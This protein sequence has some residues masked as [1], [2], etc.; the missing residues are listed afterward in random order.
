MRTPVGFSLLL[1]ALGFCVPVA[2]RA[3]TDASSPIPAT[4]FGMCPWK[5]T[6]FPPFT[7]GA[8]GHGPFS[9]PQV[10]ATRDAFSFTALEDF[11]LDAAARGMVDPSTNTVPMFVTLG[12]TPKWATTDTTTCTRGPNCN[13]PP[14]D[15]SDWSNY[16][17]QLVQH[18]DGHAF[19]HIAYYELWNEADDRIWWTPPIAQEYTLLNAMA[20]SAYAIVHADPYSQL[21]TP[22]LA[23]NVDKKASWMTTYLQGGGARDAD[24]GCYHG[25]LGSN[26]AA[27]FLWPE[28]ESGEGSV[29]TLAT[30]MRAVFDNC[31]LAGK[32]MYMTE[33]SWGS[34]TVNTLDSLT[35]AAWI[36]R[37]YLLQAGERAGTNLQSVEWFVWDDSS[38]GWGVLEHRNGAP[39][40]AV[41]AF[42]RVYQWLVGARMPNACT[43]DSTTGTWVCAMN[44][45]GGYVARAVWNANGPATWT[46]GSSF[47]RYRTLLGDS[48]AIAPGASI[49]IGTM[50]V[51]VESGVFTND[52]PISPAASARMHAVPA[53]TTAAT[54]LMFGRPPSAAG[55]VLVCD[56]AGRVVRS[57]AVPPGAPSVIW[58]GRGPTGQALASGVYFARLESPGVAGAARVVIAR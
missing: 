30:R 53:V 57:L 50:P 5:T 23:G 3:A 44:R 16:V 13:A 14:A 18:F 4:F 29:T 6:D 39:T 48:I 47:T 40:L 32:P 11:A 8:V 25:Y 2:G 41:S 26:I 45:P 22:S 31:G 21:L 20:D 42:Q 55:R 34:S 46:P 7:I 10:E 27:T 54:L 17:R 51:L 33:G 37:Y 36:A 58:D 43:L 49:P 56:V 1:L 38:F 19:P 9:W 35:Q 24:A 28:D 52:V 12:L 15:L